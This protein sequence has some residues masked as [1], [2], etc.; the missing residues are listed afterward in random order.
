M[1]WFPVVLT[2]V[3]FAATAFARP[4]TGW[5]NDERGEVALSEQD[6]QKLDT[7]EGHLLAKSDKLFA[8]KD[9]RGAA[10][11]YASFMEQYPKSTAIAYVLLRRARCLHLDNKRFDAIKAYTEV[12]D[13]FP[14]AVDYA[15]AALFYT[16]MCHFQNGD[17]AAAA[18]AWTEMAED[19]DYRKHRLAA[20]AL[21]RLGDLFSREQKLDEAAKYYM[22]VAV[23]FRKANPEVAR[24]AMGK[25]IAYLVR[26]RPD[27]SKLA[28]FYAKVRTFHQDP[29]KGSETDYWDSVRDLVRSHGGFPENEKTKRADYFRYWTGIMESKLPKDDDSQIALADFNLYVDGDVAKWIVRL[30]RQFASSSRT[31]DYSRVIRWIRLFAKQK[32]KVQDYYAKLNFSQMSNGQIEDLLRTAYE[33]LNDPGM[34]RSAYDKLQQNKMTDRDRAR[35]AGFFAQKDEGMMERVCADMSD[36]NLGRMLLLRHYGEVKNGGKGIPLANELVSVPEYAQEAYWIKAE[37]LHEQRKHA[38]AISAYQ[39]ADRPPTTLFRIAECYLGMGKIDQAV[40]QLREIEGFFKNEAPEAALRIA[41]VYRK[42]DNKQYIACL[43]GIMA[44]YPASRQS[45]TAHEE[46]ERLGI[47]IGGGV[48]AK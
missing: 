47:K 19:V 9:Y 41:Y 17:S 21:C 3:L 16:G 33:F 25:A 12:L 1:G 40:A 45:N 26:T 20:V 39:S 23:D 36:K 11:E 35:L 10:N 18:T 27:E 44:K 42:R 43:R 13:Y 24:F 34:G 37:L 48:D 22:Q 4:E 5:E 2:T 30:D 29:G 15:G 38:E 28:D 6:F 32:N 7:F 31:N 8:Q 46:L 14:N